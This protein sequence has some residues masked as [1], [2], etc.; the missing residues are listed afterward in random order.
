MSLT[1]AATRLQ[2][3]A[4]GALKQRQK[5]R[6]AAKHRPRISAFFR[7]QKRQ[8]LDALADQKYLFSESYHRLAEK[9]TIDLTLQNWD[10]IWDGISTNTL[11]EL[12]KVV[13]STEVD[14]VVAG[15]EQ[16][17]T[18]IGLFDKA[19]SF[20]LA[21][22]RAVGWFHQTGGSVD[23]IK[24]IQQTTGESL[25]R[26]IGTSLDE[27]WSYSQTAREIQKLYDGQISRDRA[28]RIAVNESAQAYE[29]GNRMFADTLKDEGVQMEKKWMT[30]QDNR[31]SDGCDM[32]MSDDWIPIDESHTSGHQQPPRFPGCRCYEIYQQAPTKK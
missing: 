6:I 11:P 4:I 2:F 5:D 23:Y 14:G 32:N 19:K 25:K 9:A 27:G 22:P 8:V 13:F 29:E 31:V 3:A 26:V 30:S 1:E 21:N 15:A 24:G 16:L 28:Q 12:Q 20:N 10:R 17:R 7:S 18:Q